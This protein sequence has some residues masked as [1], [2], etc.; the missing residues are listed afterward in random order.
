MTKLLIYD[1]EIPFQAK[2]VVDRSNIA[3]EI[4]RIPFETKN[5]YLPL[6][7]RYPSVRSAIEK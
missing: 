1:Y 7:G 3:G 2:K 4:P 6:N 5:T